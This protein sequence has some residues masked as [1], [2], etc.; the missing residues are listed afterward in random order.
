MQEMEESAAQLTQTML[1][2]ESIGI[3]ALNVG[4]VCVL[5]AV[6]EEFLFR[7][8]LQKVFGKVIKNP[9]V[10][11]WVVAIVFSAF[12]LQFYGF[13]TRMLLGAYLGYL[14]YYTQTIWI[15]ILAHFT[16]NFIGVFIVYIFQD[17]PPDWQEKADAIG[18]G[19]T[20]W[21]SVASLALFA[22]CFSKIRACKTAVVK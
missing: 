10:V 9:H 18:T 2:S 21:L 1:H 19:S 17:A 7:G 16:N 6:G 5:G 11:I 4:I 3:F 22:F 8:V 14:L 12:H 13:I 15:P 20:W